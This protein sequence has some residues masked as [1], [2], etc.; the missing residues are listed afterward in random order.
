MHI[1]RD[2]KNSNKV[3]KITLVVPRPSLVNLQEK[4]L[5][6]TDQDTVYVCSAPVKDHLHKAFNNASMTGVMMTSKESSD[7]MV[8]AV[9]KI[10]NVKIVNM[11]AININYE[12]EFDAVFSN[13][14]IHWIKDLETMY[15]L[16]Y[17]SLHPS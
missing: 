7:R 1:A 5:K 12:N 9:P 4:E 8:I 3:Q 2:P 13:S 6:P 16:I 17:K 15:N 11:D 10:K 14:A